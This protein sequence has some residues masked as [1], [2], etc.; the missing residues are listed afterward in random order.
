MAA[1]AI[2]PARNAG[3]DGAGCAP[4]VDVPYFGKIP[5]EDLCGSYSSHR[6]PTVSMLW[7]QS[8][9]IPFESAETIL[10][11]S[12]TTDLRSRD[13]CAN[14]TAPLYE[15]RGTNA[16]TGTVSTTERARV[17]A[18]MGVDLRKFIDRNFTAL[19][20]SFKAALQV[21]KTR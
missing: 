3:A 10:G 7:A 14:I 4:T 19:P 6:Q 16:F 13:Q 8:D 11:W 20:D 2:E 1:F 18:A 17:V 21:N 5:V 12:D 15:E 9:A